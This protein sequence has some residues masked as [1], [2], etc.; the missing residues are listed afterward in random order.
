MVD[1]TQQSWE[2]SLLAKG[3]LEGERDLVTPSVMAVFC[4]QIQ[5]PIDEKT[6]PV[7]EESR[8]TER[9]SD[10]VTVKSEWTPTE[11]TEE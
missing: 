3:P 11:L 6:S 2:S 9:E 4:E 8:T 7:L 10:S 1:I 5:E